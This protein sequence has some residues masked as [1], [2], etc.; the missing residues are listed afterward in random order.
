[1]AMLDPNTIES[2]CSG[3]LG[4]TSSMFAN[5]FI[6]GLLLMPPFYL[7]HRWITLWS[8]LPP[9]SADKPLPRGIRTTIEGVIRSA[10]DTL[11]VPD[12]PDRRCVAWAAYVKGYQGNKW[13]VRST[14]FSLALDDGRLLRIT[15]AT[16]HWHTNHFDLRPSPWPATSSAPPTPVDLDFI[17]EQLH[18]AR[19]EEPSDDD[20]WAS[21]DPVVSHGEARF[22]DY[23]INDRITLS[24]FFTPG[25]ETL[26]TDRY[27]GST[28]IE[29][30]SVTR[31]SALPPED[32]PP[33]TALRYW[34]GR[35][36]G[37]AA[38][39][40]ALLFRGS[41]S[42]ARRRAT[43]FYRFTLGLTILAYVLFVVFAFMVI[44]LANAALCR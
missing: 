25:S 1:M 7:Y 2:L 29:H 9:P 37:F 18:I 15:I 20:R 21:L 5:A 33:R 26:K 38:S 16:R 28:S 12:E 17:W 39:N 10:D 22:A 44:V 36:W 27:R 31:A 23:G 4:N 34:R 6:G 43:F 40:V 32:L 14:P 13:F 8:L 24:G 11:V 35:N 19:D 30:Y 42:D 41:Y 3:P